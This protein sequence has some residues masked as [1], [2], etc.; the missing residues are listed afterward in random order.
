[1]K[2]DDLRLKIELSVWG[3]ELPLY[4]TTPMPAKTAL[5]L[6]HAYAVYPLE[7]SFSHTIQFDGKLTFVK[8]GP[9]V[10]SRGIVVV[11]DAV[12]L[13]FNVNPNH[14]RGSFCEQ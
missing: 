1:L 6:D 14:S 9:A 10:G 8:F 13:V 2:R 4:Q 3:E 5:L 11:S 7:H 12:K